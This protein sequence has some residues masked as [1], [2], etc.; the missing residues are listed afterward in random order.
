MNLYTYIK[1]TINTFRNG[2]QD[3]EVFLYCSSQHLL[4]IIIGTFV[5]DITYKIKLYVYSNMGSKKPLSRYKCQNKDVLWAPQRI[6]FID[7]GMKKVAKEKKQEA[8]EMGRH[9]TIQTWEL[10]N[11]VIKQSTRWGHRKWWVLL[12]IPWRPA[13]VF[14]LWCLNFT[15]FDYPV[16]Y[17]HY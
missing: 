15:N 7:W 11:G 12:P 17:E 3:T 16:H 14:I 10:Q 4:K 8:L 6:V 1:I 9:I 13:H 2:I 5:Y